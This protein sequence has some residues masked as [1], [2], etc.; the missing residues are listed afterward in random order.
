MKK[1]SKIKFT[2]K[3]KEAI[4]DTIDNLVLQVEDSLREKLQDIM[5]DD[6]DVI[7]ELIDIGGICGDDLE[8]LCDAMVEAVVT[9]LDQN[10]VIYYR[11]KGTRRKRL[12]NY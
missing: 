9:D 8:P 2:K 10:F 7:G 1:Q 4:A 11:R 6:L 3:Q 12:M 5:R